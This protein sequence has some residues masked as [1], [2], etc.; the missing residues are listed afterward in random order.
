MRFVL[1]KLYTEAG[2]VYPVA[3]A[4]A[5]V[6]ASQ[7]GYVAWLVEKL[8]T[9]LKPEK[10][11]GVFT[12]FTAMISRE[13]PFVP[14][15]M[16]LWSAGAKVYGEVIQTKGAAEITDITH[17]VVDRPASAI[18]MTA[19][20]EY[21]QPQYILD[22]LNEGIQLSTKEYAPGAT[23]PA[24]LSPFASADEEYLPQRR[25]FLDELKKKRARAVDAGDD[26]PEDEETRAVEGEQ[27]RLRRLAKEAK[28]EKLEAEGVEAEVEEELKEKTKAKELTTDTS[29]MLSKKHRRLLDKIEGGKKI[30]RDA[31]NKLRI[32]AQKVS[33]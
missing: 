8:E 22:A 13:V 2:A 7:T 16:C 29:V 23:L 31:A 4:H 18:T 30:K 24:H 32:K 1:F 11:G 15:A 20:R 6:K 28:G 3:G 33:H 25:L 14:V 10:A 26:V 9:R 17:M 19:D 27:R 5:K 12:G 21:V